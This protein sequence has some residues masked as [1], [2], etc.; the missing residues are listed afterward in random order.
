M[1]EAKNRSLSDRAKRGGLW[2]FAGKAIEAAVRLVGNIILTWLLFREAFGVLVPVRVF[3]TGMQLFSDIGIGPSIVR[4]N[5]EHDPIFLRTIWTVQVIRGFLLYG[6]CWLFAGTYSRMVG[7]VLT[8]SGMREQEMIHSLLLVAGLSALFL[9]FR[10]PSWFTQDRQIAQGRKT[11]ISV[12]SQV[13]AMITMIVWAW[14]SPTPLAMVAGGVTGAFC[15]TLFSHLLLPGVS[16]GFRFEKEA[17]AEIYGFGRWI[18]LSTALVFFASQVDRIFITK[19]LDAA[20]RGDFGIAL[21]IAILVPTILA[22]ISGSVVF[23]A[24][25][26]SFRRTD[27]QH[28]ERV[29]RSRLGLNSICLAGLT[30]VI[31]VA[32][33]FFGLFYRDEYLGAA[34]ITQLLCIPLWFT[35]LVASC[36]NALLVHGD[37]RSVSS[38]NFIVLLMKIPACWFGFAWFGLPGFVIGMAIGN[39]AGLLRLHQRLIYHGTGLLRQ[40]LFSSLIFLGFGAVGYLVASYASTLSESQEIVLVGL[41][42]CSLAAVA[43][44]PAQALLRKR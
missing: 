5:R 31:T 22:A 18:F 13:I 41:V 42:G 12:L 20:P 29:R 40:D 3:L 26:K 27:S 8:E 10:S 21:N 6:V 1:T 32:P 9:G 36:S 24:W 16:M 19:L 14:V 43:L 44:Q 30:G 15:Q 7:E 38:A 34:V 4:T 28:V 35:A 33:T 2:V 11:L 25:M 39:I 23:P 17:L 37:S